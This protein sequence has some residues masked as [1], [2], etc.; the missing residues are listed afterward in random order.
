MKSNQE[1]ISLLDDYLKGQLDD[2]ATKK[3]LERLTVDAALAEDLEFLKSGANALRVNTLDEKLIMLKAIEASDKKIGAAKRQKKT[4]LIWLLLLLVVLI[5][6]VWKIRN[7]N[8]HTLAYQDVFASKFDTELILHKTYRSE[9][10]D[11]QLNLDQQRAY[12]MY[13]L[14]MFEEAIPILEKLWS[15]QKDTLALFYLGVSKYGVGKS[16]EGATIFGME[17][18]RKYQ[19][20]AKIFE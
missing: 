9:G 17:E 2:E 3:L 12:E 14:Q 8:P 20:Q 16:D 19:Q 6:L 11:A 18:M 10:N 4:I 1:D 15:Q 5:L 7:E 13:S